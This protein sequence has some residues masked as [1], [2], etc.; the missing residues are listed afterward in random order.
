MKRDT[1]L[2]QKGHHR[3]YSHA[4]GANSHMAKA[5]G[6]VECCLWEMLFLSGHPPPSQRQSTTLWKVEHNFWW[7]TSLQNFFS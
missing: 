2:Q 4:V 5:G 1:L 6:Q 3:C 7:T